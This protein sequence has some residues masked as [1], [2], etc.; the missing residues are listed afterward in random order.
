MSSA[1]D[2]VWFHAEGIPPLRTAPPSPGL[3]ALLGDHG[4]RVGIASRLAAPEARR[5]L[6]TLLGPRAVKKAAF[7]LL[8]PTAGK[9]AAAL[10]AAARK[11]RAASGGRI[12]VSADPSFLEAAKRAGWRTVRLDPR[13]EAAGDPRSLLHRIRGEL[14]LAAGKLPN[15]W[16]AE[17][18]QEFRF[19]DPDLLINPGVGEDIAAVDVARDEVLILKS[20]PITFATDAIGQYAVLVNAN[21]IATAGADPRWLLATLLFPPGTTPADIRGVLADLSSFCRRWG[22]TLCGGHTEITDAVLRPVVCG[23]MAG[24]VRRRKLI[25]K[26]RL[27]AGDVL[28]MT[29]AAG[30]EGTAILAREFA[31]R[32]RR[33]GLSAPALARARGFLAHVPIL[34]EARAAAA[35]PGVSAMHDVTEGGVATAVE[36]L[37]AAGGCALEVDLARIPVR[38]VTRRLCRLLGLDPLGL[39]GSGSLLIACRPRHAPRLE[40]TIREA[41]IEIT[42]IGEVLRKGVGVRGMRHGRPV[43]WPRFE[44]DEIARLFA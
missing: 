24:R 41:G 25:D 16:L 39:I 29:K 23:M 30:I 6:G 27:R 31:A 44:V 11:A 8:P 34:P 1:S 10:R 37:A 4:L 33:L 18:L 26:R 19:E 32:L 20:D 28:F 40:R 3:A 13:G 2:T 17:F 9:L 7:L 12:A 36:E 21:D 38:P 14:P 35:C 43:P 22:I 42:R 5:R 15:A